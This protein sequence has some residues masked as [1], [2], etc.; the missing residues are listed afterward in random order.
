MDDAWLRTLLEAAEGGDVV[1]DPCQHTA[2]AVEPHRLDLR[3]TV[4]TI[5]SW[6]IVFTFNVSIPQKPGQRI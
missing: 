3:R 2:A 4:G 6:A 1:T 5:S